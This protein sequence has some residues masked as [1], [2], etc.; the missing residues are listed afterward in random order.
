MNKKMRRSNHMETKE[1]LSNAVGEVLKI[2][3]RI[4]DDVAAE[5]ETVL[6]EGLETPMSKEEAQ[7]LFRRISITIKMRALEKGDLETAKAIGDDIDGLVYEITK[8]RDA[9]KDNAGGRMSREHT[10]HLLENYNGIKPAHVVPRPW[11]HGKEIPMISGYIKTTDIQLWDE[12]VRLDIHIGQFK[13]KYGRSPSPQELLEIMLSNLQLPGVTENDQF[14]I[15]ELARSIAINGVRKP[16][17]IDI[18]GTL[19]DGNRRVTACYYILSNDEFTSDQKKRAEHIFVWQLTPDATD[20]DRRRVI[21][22]LNFE[23]DYKEPWPEY[24]K[25]RKVYEDWQA[26]L[27]AEQPKPG[28]QR[29]AA[30]KRELSL[31]YALGPDATNVTRYTQMV[32]LA[33]DFEDYHI[34]DK[35]KDKYAVQHTSSKYFQYFDELK[36]GSRPGGVLHSLNQD[37]GFK[38]T[39]FDLLYDGKFRN[40][41]Q[42]RKLKYIFENDEAVERLRKARDESDLETAQDLVEEAIA[43]ADTKRADKRSLGA[44]TRIEIFVKWLEELPV[45]AFRDEISKENLRRLLDALKLVEKHSEDMIIEKRNSDN[46]NATA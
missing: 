35:K 28:P 4:S 12:N 7:E 24:V 5:V 27:S 33:N 29:Q 17:I 11:F 6:K 25:A 37:D 40:W 39:V 43:I 41:N 3:R 32:E 30:M 46:A 38:K 8:E 2:A 34:E 15:I 13:E 9:P 45:K 21:V 14:E 16:P 36:K 1:Y 26:M 20:D 22:S 10:I 44:N 31:K 23:P 18:D 42:I 19:L